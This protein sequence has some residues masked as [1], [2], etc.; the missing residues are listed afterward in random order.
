MKHSKTHINGIL[1]AVFIAALL[2]FFCKTSDVT[3]YADSS[4]LLTLQIPG[5]FETASCRGML[6]NINDLRAN[7]AWYW[8]SSDTAKVYLSDLTPLVY[9]YEL[10]RVAM[11]RAV[12]LAIKY[13]HSRPDE[14]DCFSAYTDR[15]RQGY[16]GEN[17]AYGQT[18]ASEVFVGWA[19]AEEPYEGQGHRRNML[20]PDFR[21]VGIGCFECDGILFWAQE[22]SSVVTG[23]AS[24]PLVPPV[25]IDVLRENIDGP[26]ISKD[27]IDMVA[28]Q[29]VAL[30]GIGFSVT[31]VY[32]PE[33]TVPCMDPDIHY[34][35]ADPEIA[36]ISGGMLLAVSEGNTTLTISG[37]GTSADIAVNVR[38]TN[39]YPLSLDQPMDVDVP[40]GETVY[41]RFMPSETGVYT[42]TSHGDYDTIC[43]LYDSA[44][45][46]I[47][48]DDDGGSGFNFSLSE[49][50]TAGSQYYYGVYLY[51][52]YESGTISVQLT[53]GDNTLTNG[54][55]NYTI[56]DDETIS[57][58]ECLIEG[59]IVIPDSING[60]PVVN[61]ERGLFFEAEGITSVTIPASVTYFGDNPNDNNWDYVFSYCYDLE[62]IF[63][64]SANPAFC[65]VD[66][67]LYEKDYK[68]LI[69]YP[70]RHSGNVYHVNAD[71]LS[72]AAFASCRNL[73]F[74][75]L[76][77][78]DT[79]W[80]NDTF[81]DTGNMTLFYQANGL[82]G[83]IVAD[84]TAAGREYSHDSTYCRF[85]GIEEIQKLPE[86]TTEIESEAFRSTGIKYLC[87]PDSCRVIENNAFTSGELQYISVPGSVVIADRSFDSSVVIEER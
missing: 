43:D 63:V 30:S 9:D 3:A 67:V 71:L 87:V 59:D 66:G 25:S 42:F 68:T 39:E 60:Y 53:K 4:D 82:T 27:R 54:D 81:F 78:P 23:A 16:C 7:D 58:K 19:E 73:K 41:F 75:F 14:S 32:S 64:D 15:L 85:A 72:R 48:S 79:T 29:S 40:E 80:Y 45:E 37:F 46:H 8:N 52:A 55:F 74:L 6:D 57:I 1:S 76:D 47:S 5:S 17:I 83:Q 28:G 22:F 11:Q 65:S 20:S 2:L 49:E 86:N 38:E 44:Y 62:N 12:E 18:S 36:E 24:D 21:A 33:L 13:A 35:L 69:S 31:D 61:L 10:E 50:L 51:N 34:T 77:N 26:V 84:E 70:C 56:L